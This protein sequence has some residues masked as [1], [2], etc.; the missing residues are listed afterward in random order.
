[1]AWHGPGD[2]PLSESMVVRSLTHICVTRPQWVNSLWLV[3]SI[4]W[5][6]FGSTLIAR[7]MAITWTNVDV[8]SE[9]FCGTSFRAIL[10]DV[11]MKLMRNI[12]LEFI[13]LE[14]L[15]HLPMSWSP[16]NTHSTFSCSLRHEV[17]ACFDLFQF[18]LVSSEHHHSDIT[19]ASQHRKS[20]GPWFNIKMSSY[21]YRKSHCGDKTVVRSSYLHNRISYTGKMT[22]LYWFGPL[23]FNCLV[24]KFVQ[25]NNKSNIKPLSEPMLIDHQWDSVA[26]I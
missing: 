26:L 18:V 16:C 2:K 1:M 22:S 9:E 13:L 12:C 19:W 10:Q 7:I 15:P 17:C 23:E 4:W 5:H 20:P 24:E 25:A 14:L 3:D 6:R 11:L 21:Q 8:S